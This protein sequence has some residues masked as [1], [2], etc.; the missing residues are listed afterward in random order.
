V[1]GTRP[2]PYARPGVLPPAPEKHSRD[3]RSR[4]GHSHAD[5]ALKHAN[6]DMPASKKGEKGDGG[7]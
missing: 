6:L 7:N 2:V 3:V 4:P 1:Y 5:N